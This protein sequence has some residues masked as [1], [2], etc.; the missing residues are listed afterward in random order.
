MTEKQCSPK[1]YAIT[2]LP[3]GEDIATTNLLQQRRPAH[4]TFLSARG[5]PALEGPQRRRFA[6]ARD[7]LSGDS[8]EYPAADE[9]RQSPIE[10]ARTADKV[11]AQVAESGVAGQEKLE[12]VR[13]LKVER[14][15]L[16]FIGAGVDSVLSGQR[17]RTV[18]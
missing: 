14:A 8:H 17:R 12:C 16:V 15:R 6:Y 2:S 5:L 3:P 11:R 7:A 1:A 13:D 4:E 10:G 9:K 18:P